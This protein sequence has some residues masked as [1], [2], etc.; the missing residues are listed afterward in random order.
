MDEKIGSKIDLLVEKYFEQALDSLKTIVGIKSVMNT[1]EENMPFGEGPAKALLETLRI[2]EQLGFKTLN[3]DNYAGHVTYGN[4]GKLY[5]ILGHL[6][7]VPEGDLEKWNSNPYELNIRNGKMYGRG[8]SDDKGP[9]IGALYALKIATELVESPENTV[10]IVFGTN[11]ENGSNC[12]KYYFKKQPYP[13]VAVTPDGYFPV[14]FAEKGNV[15]YQ[16]STGLKNDYHT[17]LLKMNAGVAPNVVPETCEVVIKTEK[18]NEI[19]YTIK[20]HKSNCSF[21]YTVNGDEITIRSIGKSAHGA[22]PELGINAASCMLELLTKI[23]FGPGNWIFETLF[24]KIGKDVNGK[25]LDIFGE[26]KISGQLTCNLGILRFEKDRLY[27]IINIRYPIFFNEEMIT[28]QIKEALK[29]FDIEEKSHSK[30]LYVSKDSS[31]IK[32]LLNVYRSVTNDE[33]EPIAIGGGTYVRRVPYGVTF[34]A[35][36]PGEDT[37]MHQPNENWSLES[38]KKFIRIYARLIYTWLTE[39]HS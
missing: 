32:S 11:E 33:S 29:G 14:I 3:V 30:P 28:I 1:P 7:V 34:G 4:K 22:S 8:V 23:D 18:V 13:D 16:L 5:A 36:F 12:L 6:D 19:E 27:A 17:K 15:T 35:T 9:S 2:C 31:L 38:F 37:A 25:G 10:R 21:E 26:D 39:D 20:N 24:E